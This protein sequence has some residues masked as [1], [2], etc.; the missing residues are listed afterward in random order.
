M[1]HS[2]LSFRPMIESDLAVVSDIEQRSTPHPWRPAH[3]SDSI[4]SG[5]QCIVAEYENRVIGHAVVMTAMDQAD[6]LIITIDQLFQG[7]GFGTAL[8][9]QVMDIAS[10]KNCT[11]LLLEVRQS[12]NKAF[13]L[14]LDK[15]FSE[16]GIRKN[17]YPAGDSREDAII[18]AMD[19]QSLNI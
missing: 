3:F 13:N 15:G 10:Q 14:Y 16:I 8:L 7:K 6:L 19:L 18:M 17:Y 5:Y 12:N 2:S 4:K 9:N 1:R 11:T